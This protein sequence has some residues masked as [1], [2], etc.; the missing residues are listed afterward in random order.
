MKKQKVTDAFLAKWRWSENDR[1]ANIIHVGQYGLEAQIN[2]SGDISF[3]IRMWVKKE[4]RRKVFGYFE[5]GVYGLDEALDDARKLRREWRDE[6]AGKVT[7]RPEDIPN[8]GDLIDHY[9]ARRKSGVDPIA[10]HRGLPLPKGWDDYVKMMQKIYKPL[11]F[12]NVRTITRED[13]IECHANYLDERERATGN[14]PHTTVR[15]T[16]N[17]IKP[18][19]VYARDV[20][21]LP[22]ET[23]IGLRATTV[24]EESRERFL[25][26]GEWQ[27]VAPALDALSNDTGLLPRFLLGT[28]CR[29]MMACLMKWDD[30][31][32]VD[33]TAAAGPQ[34]VVT[35]FI[36]AENMK[37]GQGALLPLV[38][39]ALAIVEMLRARAGGEPKKDDYVFPE[40]VRKAW[41]N[42][43]DRWQKIVFEKSGTK[44]WHRHDLRRTVATLLK[45]VGAD[46]ETIKRVLSHKDKKDKSSTGFYIRL[47]GNVEAMIRMSDALQKV[48]RLL[49]DMEE[50]R[51]TGEL[52]RLYGELDANEAVKAWITELKL[53]ALVEVVPNPKHVTATVH[54]LHPV[55][56]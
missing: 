7:I 42:N 8:L 56:A 32:T 30:I 50:G 13:I 48:H 19:L 55:S 14:R 37:M 47:S 51:V 12:R 46:M 10:S 24:V 5:P 2:K 43:P 18:V 31:R 39:D 35:W 33:L 22:P 28:G 20:R 53:G 45:F 25:L 15:F 27:R 34:K 17:A 40:N 23:L 36:P 4:R 16:F 9:E 1:A 52:R 3:G 54:T 44:G 21:W 29:L 38:G 41:M 11:W 49:K 26:P 6:A